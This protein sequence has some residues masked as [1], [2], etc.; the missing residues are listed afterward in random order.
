MILNKVGSL[1]SGKTRRMFPKFVPFHDRPRQR[2]LA[3]FRRLK[4]KYEAEKAKRRSRR[5]DGRLLTVNSMG[6][7]FNVDTWPP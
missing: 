6:R 3:K 5:G 7:I 1:A 4:K 2:T